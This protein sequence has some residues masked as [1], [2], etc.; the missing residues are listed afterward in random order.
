MSEATYQ[1]LADALAA[2]IQ[3]AGD[4]RLLTD[5]VVFAASIPGEGVGTRYQYAIRENLPLHSLLGLLDR[6]QMIARESTTQA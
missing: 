6:A 1:A 2:H 4:G 5:W 3:D